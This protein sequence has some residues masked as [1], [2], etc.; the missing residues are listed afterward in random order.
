MNTF[1]TKMP[2]YSHSRLSAFEQCPLKFKL[3]YLDKVETEVE[4]GVEAFLGKKVHETLEKLYRDLQMQ[5]LDSLQELL[6]FLN[7]GWKKSWNDE[8]VI[9]KQ[10]YTPELY[11]KLAE[12]MVIDY[13][14]RYKP[15]NHSR[16]IACES[17]VAITLDDKGDYMLQ[18]YIDRLG[19]VEPGIYEIHDYKTSSSLPLQRYLDDDRQLA[20]YQLAVKEGYSDAQKIRLIWH[21]LAFDKELKS[22]RTDEQLELLKAETLALI[23]RIESTTEFPAKESKLCGWCE[24]RP[25]CPG[26]KHLYQLEEKEPK[27]YLEDNGV[28]LVNK[29]ASLNEKK[30]R[31]VEELDSQLEELKLRIIEFAERQRVTVIFGSDNKIRIAVS[32]SVKLPYKNTE[33]RQ[34]LNELLKKLGKWEEVAEL[35][36]FAL[37]KVIKNKSWPEEL[38]GQ[39]EK[40]AEMEKS[41]RL[42][43][44]S[45]RKE[46]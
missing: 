13:Y 22:T 1:Q 19:F 36:I 34:E 21:F 42:Y 12:K 29:Y 35:D 23:K 27:K 32:D 39:L 43:V 17:R 18:G 7:D 45:I 6:K 14:H 40:F 8:I 41:Y 38:L 20:L 28:Q 5:K 33:E 16:T 15:F 3:R 46:E 9:V 26:F 44:G 2:S 10:D 24:F 31:L 11:L 25:M 4:E 30:R 37:A